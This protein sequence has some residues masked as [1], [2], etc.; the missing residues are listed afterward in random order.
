MSVPTAIPPVLSSSVRGPL[1][2][3]HLPR[4]W[5]KIRLFAAGRLPDGYRHGVGGFDEFVLTTL[6]V[7]RDA[8][9]AFVEN[10]KPDYPAVEDYVR[11]HATNLNGEAIATINTRIDTFD[12]PEELLADR[13]QR[14]RLEPGYTKGVRVN[15]IDDWDAFHTM[16]A[17]G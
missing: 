10:E 7:D 16:L 13:R 14:L 15:D 8:F 2:V 9:I 12:M 4:V 3:A 17:A 5:L 11:A 1:G 6:G